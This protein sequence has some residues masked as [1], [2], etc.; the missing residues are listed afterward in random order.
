VPGKEKKTM[1]ELTRVRDRAHALLGRHLDST[2]TF[3]FDAA[4]KRAGLCDYSAKRISVSRYL[5]ARWSDDEVD[6]VL[7]HEIAHALAGHRAGHGARWLSVARRLGYTGA[8]LHDGETASELAPWTGRCPNGHVHYRFRAPTAPLSCRLCG[9][10][11]SPTR[12]ISWTRR[13]VSTAGRRAAM[14][15]TDAAG[16]R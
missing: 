5:A 14:R 1:A 7:L 6:Q 8:R 2:W 3:G 15:A 9:P 16:L 10:G 4:K 12:A 11:F 13:E